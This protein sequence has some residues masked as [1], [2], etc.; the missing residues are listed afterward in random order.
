MIISSQAFTKATTCKVNFILQVVVIV[1]EGSE[2][3]PNGSTFPPK[4]DWEAPYSVI[5][6]KKIGDDIVHPRWKHQDNV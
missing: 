4:A 5:F 3:I 2:T 1:I 6:F